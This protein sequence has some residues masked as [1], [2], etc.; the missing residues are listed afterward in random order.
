[1]VCDNADVQ[2]RC[3]RPLLIVVV[4]GIALRCGLLVVNLQHQESPWNAA[5]NSGSREG[6][7]G[8]FLSPV[9]FEYGNIAVSC[10]NGT[11]YSSPFGGAT[12]PTAWSAPIPVMV[13]TGAFALG[14]SFSGAS[15][16]ILDGVTI[17]LSVGL[18][19]LV[20]FI[21]REVSGSDR[22]GMVAAVLVAATPYDAWL[23][24]GSNRFDLNLVSVALCG[25]VAAGMWS[26]RQAGKRQILT[27]AAATV[28]AVFTSPVTLLPAAGVVVLSLARL[29]SRQRVRAA[30]IWLGVVVCCVGPF[31]LWQHHRTGIWCLVK[32]NAPF[33]L[34]L[35]NTPEARGV[36]TT[37]AFRRHH[38]I[39]NPEMFAVYE[40]LGEAGFQRFAWRRFLAE[41]DPRTFLENTVRRTVHFFLVHH[42]KPWDGSATV[43]AKKVL[44]AVPAIILIL[45]VAVFKA[46]K[47]RTRMLMAAVFLYSVPYLLIAV[48][49]RYKIPMMPLIL[50]MAA[51]L[52]ERAEGLWPRRESM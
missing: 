29:P 14:G 39:Q 19:L 24:M 9:G 33:E 17:F 41:T 3:A 32:S 21:A 5:R 8:P 48:M 44:W 25:V 27:L 45:M 18:I 34:F 50:T 23:L 30:A 35:G 46:G 1:M 4:V 16:L 28:A 37:D 38:P 6:L 11:G 7:T 47:V 42:E 52:L 20:Y 43:Y 51:L 26:L 13:Y 15:A 31:V 12:G 36:L 10:L 40:Q 22:A 49:D 2:F